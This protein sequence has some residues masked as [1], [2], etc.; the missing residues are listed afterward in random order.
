M[1]LA[2]G[3]RAAESELHVVIFQG[4]SSLPLLAAQQQGFFAARGLKV[5]VAITPSSEALRTGLAAGRFEIAHAAVDNA[6][7]M[8]EVAHAEIAIVLGGD[9]GFTSVMAQPEIASYEALKGRTVVV[10]APDTAY[11]LMLYRILELH[12]LKRGDYAVKPLGATY[13]RLKAMQE[14]K[15]NA[16]SILTPPFTFVAA[17]AGLKDLGQA[18]ASIGA[19]QANGAFV[20]RTWAR[21]NRDA[22]VR[23]IAAYVEG[24]RWAL[25]P[26]HKDAAEALIAS[27]LKVSPEIAARCYALAAARKGGFDRDAAIN[28]AGMRNVLRLRAEFEGQWGGK[29][30]P[31]GRYLDL[32]YYRSA[33]KAM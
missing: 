23:Y 15:A 16:A 33:L 29:L 26:A 14:D 12:G 7:A 8:V 18:V 30:P 31:A 11:A 20:L 24:L 22:L 32:S 28:L 21:Q 4:I 25:N 10:D 13:L 9:D 5:D 3:A 27:A 19:Y 17:A 6:I 2:A 1:L